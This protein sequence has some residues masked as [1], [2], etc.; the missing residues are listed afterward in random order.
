MRA[1][2]L[3]GKPGGA[4]VETRVEEAL[5]SVERP[6][7]RRV[8]NAAGVV[9]HTNLGRAPLGATTAQAGYSNL[10]YDLAAGRR[11]RAGRRWSG[12]RPDR[13]R[14]RRRGRSAAPAP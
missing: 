2:I 13:R 10:E 14:P 12:R 5:A 4:A 1:A 6:S 9:L 8:I 7:L 3:S 11:I